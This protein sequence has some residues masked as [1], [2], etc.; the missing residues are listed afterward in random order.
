MG[1]IKIT[2]IYYQY[3]MTK[4]A[5][6]TLGDAADPVTSEFTA[7][8][9]LPG[10]DD[11]YTFRNKADD[12][13]LVAKNL[14]EV[15]GLITEQND[16][17]GRN[18]KSAN[19][20]DAWGESILPLVVHANVDAAKSAIM[21]DASITSLNTHCDNQSWSLVDGNKGL[22]HTRDH[23]I[24]A[25]AGQDGHSIQLEAAIQSAWSGG[26]GNGSNDGWL[27]AGCILTDSDD[28]LF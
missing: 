20:K 16:Q 18:G 4:D 9:S 22:K 5:F 12:G 7:A 25:N 3:N 6:T 13:W 19:A 8:A 11:N 14:N 24:N 1:V 26:S 15:M 17:K 27:K 10:D 2:K 23:K 21:P 28:H